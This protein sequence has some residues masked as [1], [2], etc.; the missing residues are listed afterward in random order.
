MENLPEAVRWDPATNPPLGPLVDATPRPLPARIPHKGQSVDLEPLHI[1]HAEDLWRAA[2]RDTGG[3]GWAYM[4]YG[5]FRDA[6]AMRAHV[7][8]FAVT[9]DPIAWAIRPHRT[10]TADGW[11]TLMQIAPAHADI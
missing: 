2:E 8:G 5:P 11:L 6:A 4:G 10:G 1:R 9:H 3:E 7:A